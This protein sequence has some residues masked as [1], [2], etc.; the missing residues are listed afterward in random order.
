[1]KCLRLLF[2]LSLL[3]QG[4]FVP[5]NPIENPLSC[6]LPA[7]DWITATN[8]TSSSITVEWAD[9]NG[10]Y[11]YRVSRF[12]VTNGVPL[13]DVDVS[14]P[15]Y[16]SAPHDPGTTISFE[17]SP[18]C[19]NEELGG[20]IGDDYTTNFIIVDDI[21]H[22]TA[23]NPPP[24][25]SSVFPGTDFGPMVLT[26]ANKNTPTV[27]VYRM[28]A[29]YTDILGLHSAEFLMWSHCSTPSNGAPRVMY[30]D[31]SGWQG[32]ITYVENHLNNDPYGPIVSISFKSY[33]QPFF[34]IYKAAMTFQEG[35]P[36]FGNLS[37]RNDHNNYIYVGR[38]LNSEHN[39]CYV[40]QMK[41]GG[42]NDPSE[43]A[44]FDPEETQGVERSFAPG[45]LPSELTVGPNPFSNG[46]SANYTLEAESP[47]TFFLF[48]HTGREIKTMRLPNLPAGQYSTSISTDN[49]PAGIYLLAF[50][51]N[52][53]R[54][55]SRLVKQ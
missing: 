5:A 23:P 53:G 47:V 18:I 11:G 33:N 48:D 31:Q 9:V 46:F 50:Q 34:T 36:T 7:P 27:G 38:M 35:V 44:T 2:V 29:H 51:T 20:V 54:T 10:A 1:M 28:E 49:L 4:L 26:D 32:N 39:P 17:V 14:E 25:S 43:L 3:L 19:Q 22:F 52:Q 41:G 6:S 37:I 55:V 8:I 13:P 30:W 21:V 16:T 12:D 42:G 40:N 15:E 45:A 24:Y